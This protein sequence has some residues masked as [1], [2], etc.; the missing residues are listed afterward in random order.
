MT[1]THHDEAPPNGKSNVTPFCRSTTFS[2]SIDTTTAPF[3][4]SPT[5]TTY[6]CPAAWIIAIL[7][8]LP[9]MPVS[10]MLALGD[11]AGGAAAAATAAGL[12]AGTGPCGCVALRSTVPTRR[13]AGGTG[14]AWR[15]AGDVVVVPPP[16]MLRYS[17]ATTARP[18]TPRSQGRLDFDR[19]CVVASLPTPAPR[20]RCSSRPARGRAARTRPAAPSRAPAST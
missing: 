4:F 17:T 16:R 6:V 8:W 15:T 12:T 11:T 10:V 20:T 5:P 1:P 3:T 2:G 13:T 7:G 19:R 9:T 14:D 18:S